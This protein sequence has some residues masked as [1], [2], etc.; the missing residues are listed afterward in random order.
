MI[1]HFSKVIVENIINDEST[2]YAQIPFINNSYFDFED[3]TNH[4]LTL[5][6]DK[7]KAIEDDFYY[8]GFYPFYRHR[9]LD[10]FKK[11]LS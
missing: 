8:E 2:V 5:E 3:E 6:I 10:T 9:D 11:L 1:V 4:L 7:E